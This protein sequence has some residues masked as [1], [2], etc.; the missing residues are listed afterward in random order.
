M[1]APTAT[2]CDG[3]SARSIARSRR[4]TATWRSICR[5]GATPS[6]PSSPPVPGMSR[7]G[8]RASAS[9]SHRFP[10]RS[11]GRYWPRSTAGAWAAR[12]TNTSSTGSRSRSPQGRRLPIP[13]LP[14]EADP[15][16]VVGDA[17]LVGGVVALGGVVEEH[18]G[19]AAE[20]A[21]AVR[22]GSEARSELLGSWSSRREE[23]PSAS[24]ETVRF[25]TRSLPRPGAKVAASPS[26]CW[27]RG[28]RRSP[29]S[30]GAGVPDTTAD[31]YG[32]LTEDAWCRDHRF[33]ENVTLVNSVLFHPYATRSARE[34]SCRSCPPPSRADW[35]VPAGPGSPAHGGA[36]PVRSS[37][38]R[39]GYNSHPHI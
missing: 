12:C 7:S 16:I 20:H 2:S 38:P 6:R 14:V 11:S 28:V 26:G 24:V 8:G 10:R 15:R 3:T 25:D 4:S 23:E 30:A 17:L 22:H 37:H 5:S 21:V 13:G 39:D 29:K 18:G 19:L 27:R 9:S 31:L 35:D 1:N 34:S 36:Q 32:R 33:S